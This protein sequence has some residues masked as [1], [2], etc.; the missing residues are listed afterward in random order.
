[1]SRPTRLFAFHG[2]WEDVDHSALTLLER[3]GEKVT[4]PYQYFLVEHPS[5]R[6]MFDTGASPRAA[7]E[8]DRYPPTQAWGARVTEQDLAPSRLAEVGL[9]PEL[10]DLVVNSHLHYDHAGGNVFFGAATFLVQSEELRGAREPERWEL[11]S[12]HRPDFELPVRWQELDG[13][14][15]VFGDGQVTLIQT[16]GH[17]RGSQSLV[18]KL[19]E[20]GTLILAQDAVLLSESIELFK[21]PAVCWELRAAER[22]FHRIDDLRRTVGATVVPGHDPDVWAGMRKAPEAYR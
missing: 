6:M 4:V 21:V 16:P 22:S 17:T 10:I 13:D 2:G 3:I 7:R 15:D 9:K 5:G 19:D 1:M 20:A 8:P 12:F 18:L 14:Y 11:G